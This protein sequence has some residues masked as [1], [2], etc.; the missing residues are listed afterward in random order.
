MKF[1]LLIFCF[2]CS[3]ALIAQKKDTIL[4]LYNTLHKENTELKKQLTD[5]EKTVI[6]VETEYKALEKIQSNWLTAIGIISTLIILAV[7]FTAWNSYNVAKATG[8]KASADIKTEFDA[9]KTEIKNAQ[10][11][12]LSLNNESE[13]TLQKAKGIV[14]SLN[15]INNT[16]NNT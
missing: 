2:V 14:S 8:E 7:G 1:I 9:M 15:T 11:K 13:A 12:L 5:V 3:N 6:R 10:E 16:P 4:T